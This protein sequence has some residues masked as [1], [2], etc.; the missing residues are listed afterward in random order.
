[1]SCLEISSHQAVVRDE[2]IAFIGDA[3]PLASTIVE[4][5]RLPIEVE[6]IAAIR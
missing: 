2:R 4:V 1:L 3:T 5:S 6:A